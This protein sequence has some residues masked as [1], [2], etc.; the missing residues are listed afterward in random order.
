MKPNTDRRSRTAVSPYAGAPIPFARVC[1]LTPFID[2]LTTI[3]APADRLLHHAHIPAGLLNDPEGLVPLVPSC[4]FI[5]LVARRE[6]VE[7]LGMVLGQR[8]S[9]FELGA[10]GMALQGA[11]TVYQYLQTGIRL[12]GT[13]SSGTRFWLSAEGDV[14]RVNQY[15]KEPAGLGRAVGRVTAGRRLPRYSCGCGISRHELAHP[16]APPG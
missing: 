14:F 3:G 4:R 13:H 2:F 7:D 11:S 15:L 12:I 5:E 16:A 10:Y 6:H 1:A 8:A 9:A